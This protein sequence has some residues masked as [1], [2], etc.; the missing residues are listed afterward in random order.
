MS[1]RK[2]VL[3]HR[4]A[5]KFIRSVLA[6][7]VRTWQVNVEHVGRLAEIFTSVSCRRLKRLALSRCWSCWTSYTVNAK[8]V[9]LQVK[10]YDKRKL[11]VIQHLLK[12]MS[13]RALSLAMCRWCSF[14]SDAR[15]E[16]SQQQ[17][18][19][20]VKRLSLS[21][22]LALSFCS[23]C[24]KRMVRQ[25]LRASLY[26][27]IDNVA[28]TRTARRHT[29]K[30]LARWHQTVTIISFFSWRDFVCQ[31][32]TAKAKRNHLKVVISRIFLGMCREALASAFL[33]LEQACYTSS[34]SKYK[35]LKIEAA[36][37]RLMRGS[38]V[39]CIHEWL[40]HV[41][42]NR[43]TR[44]LVVAKLLKRSLREAF[45]LWHETVVDSIRQQILILRI[46]VRVQLR[47]A[48][49]TIGSW[50][51]HVAA[52]KRLRI[53]G[54]RLELRIKNAGMFAA[55]QWWQENIAE[56][57]ILIPVLRRAHHD[58]TRN[59]VRSTAEEVRKRKW[60]GRIVARMLCRSLSSVMDLWQRSVSAARQERA[61]KERR[62]SII[63]R[64]LRRMV[65]QAQAA[66]LERWITNVSELAR[67]RNIMDR[68]LRRML[69]AKISAG[70]T[71]VGVI[72]ACSSESYVS[73]VHPESFRFACG[74]RRVDV[75]L[76]VRFRWA[77]YEQWHYNVAEKK[78]VHEEAIMCWGACPRGT[79]WVIHPPPDFSTT[80][81]VAGRWVNRCVARTTD[82]WHEYTVEEARKRNEMA[83]KLQRLQKRGLVLAKDLWHK[84]VLSSLQERAEEEWRSAVMQRVVKR[85]MY[86]AVATSIFRWCENVRELRRQRGVME[87]VA[88][89]MKNAGMFAAFQW[90]RESTTETKAM[91]ARDTELQILVAEK[92]LAHEAT[93]LVS[94]QQARIK[95]MEED[96]ATLREACAEL[97]QKGRCMKEERMWAQE[98]VED[99]VTVLEGSLVDLERHY[100]ALQ[101]RSNGCI[102]T[103][104]RHRL[105]V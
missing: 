6:R 81:K 86:A 48:V 33:A 95:E 76:K 8:S 1:A 39:A 3:S 35:Q 69:N 38:L 88:L 70:P 12:R 13:M 18:S 50:F 58:L 67:Q 16:E 14:A 105:Y 52:G 60:M 41:A 47:L 64:I 84:H 77:A 15:A 26:C 102:Y 87:R 71:A 19:L 54:R 20:E 82:A 98:R 57:K 99:E 62:Q 66:A 31:M 29:L 85:R 21:F 45:L 91:R 5:G 34:C 51:Q 97:Q 59:H 68:I 73:Y 9:S 17:R 30:L 36:V 80:L 96:L 43:R 94:Q 40:E 27:W 79:R 32:A 7:V 4:L 93:A 74:C 2:G 56:K 72:A 83:L 104:V 78:K 44:S 10:A 100:A 101:V 53:A 75:W 103:S 42:A 22:S 25:T 37:Q 65:N 46:V 11:V 28:Q 63:S 90:W 24:V 23:R 89:R 92:Q 61:E 55:F 49:W